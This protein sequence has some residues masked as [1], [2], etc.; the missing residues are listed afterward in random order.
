MSNL[1]DLRTGFLFG[2]PTFITGVARLVDLWG[3]FDHYNGAS[4]ED[5]ADAIA[6]YS[7]W[8]ITGQDLRDAMND[9]GVP[10]REHGDMTEKNSEAS[11]IHD[12]TA[13]TGQMVCSACGCP[14]EFKMNPYQMPSYSMPSQS[15][16]N[17][18]R[19]RYDG[20]VATP[21]ESVAFDPFPKKIGKHVE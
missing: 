14:I 10:Y 3:V 13:S 5:E 21:K 8:R 9:F 4:S 12:I 17:L 11:G 18:N 7:D 6:L 2:T 16:P 1:K 15:N 19:W 20:V